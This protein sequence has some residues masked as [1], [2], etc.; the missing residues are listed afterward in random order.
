MTIVGSERLIVKIRP[1]PER[2]EVFI[3]IGDGQPV[4]LLN[5]SR[6]TVEEDADGVAFAKLVMYNVDCEAEIQLGI[7]QA[8]EVMKLESRLQSQLEKS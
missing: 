3:Q 6:V 8:G 2:S 1:Y 5:V 7:D 4:K